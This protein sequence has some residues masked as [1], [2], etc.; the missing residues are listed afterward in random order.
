MVVH[1]D[2]EQRAAALHLGP[3]LTDTERQYLTC[4]A[5]CEVWFE[6]DGAPLGAGRTTR[7]INRRHREVEL[8]PQDR[9]I[10]GL[11]DVPRDRAALLDEATRL[12]L[13]GALEIKRG[14]EEVREPAVVRQVLEKELD[15][16]Y[17]R[18]AAAALLV[19]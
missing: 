10:L 16:V 19:D 14:D 11:L 8:L 17:Q 13:A 2:V 18:L 3:L 4:D 15:D 5:T 7:V 1:V 12:A 6:R 9:L